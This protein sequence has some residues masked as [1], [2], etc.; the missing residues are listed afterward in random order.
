MAIY[1]Q[2]I[3]LIAWLL[4]YVHAQQH[5]VTDDFAFLWEHAIFIITE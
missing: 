5:S 4:P 2:Q 1:L 3:E